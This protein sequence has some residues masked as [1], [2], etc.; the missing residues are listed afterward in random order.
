MQ[1]IDMQSQELATDGSKLTKT[2]EGSLVDITVEDADLFKPDIDIYADRGS[3][4]VD[5]N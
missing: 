3:N 4:C 1:S 5:W 2:L